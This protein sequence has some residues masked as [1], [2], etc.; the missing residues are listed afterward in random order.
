[1]IKS[2]RSTCRAPLF[3]MLCF[4]AVGALA[5]D[6]PAGKATDEESTKSDISSHEVGHALAKPAQ[7]A[8]TSRPAG[9]VPANSTRTPQSARPGSAAPARAMQSAPASPASPA[10]PATRGNPDRPVITGRAPNPAGSPG[11]RPSASLALN[12]EK[13]RAPSVRVQSTH[14]Q[15]SRVIVRGWDNKFYAL[16]DG[17]YSDETGQQLVVSQGAVGAQAGGDMALKGKKILQNAVPDGKYA[18]PGGAWIESSGGK[19]VSVGGQ[20]ERH[21]PPPFLDVNGDGSIAVRDDDAN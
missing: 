11:D 9:P 13:I 20:L 15:Q 10:T 7:P 18:G 2:A 4:L 16:P 6:E 1:M 5:A 12:F 19:I 14:R 3:A 8:V 21:T 17:T